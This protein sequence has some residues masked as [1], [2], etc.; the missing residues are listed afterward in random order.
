MKL[1]GKD[2]EGSLLS[3]IHS[4]DK[5]VDE[6]LPVSSITTF[7]VVVSLLLKTTEWCLQLEWPQEVVGFLEVRSNGH[8]LMDQILHADDTMLS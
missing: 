4:P 3:S 6:V 5:L 8:D 2:K 7:D 1:M